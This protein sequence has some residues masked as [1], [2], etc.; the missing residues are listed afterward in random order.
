MN[1]VDNCFFLTDYTKKKL[2]FGN[3]NVFSSIGSS[4]KV[5]REQV[6]RHGLD[7]CLQAAVGVH[8]P[9]PF[10][11]GG[12]VT[13]TAGGPFSPAVLQ[14]LEL[15][16]GGA[17]G[18]LLQPVMMII[19]RDAKLSVMSKHS[20][21]YKNQMFFH[22]V[23]GKGIKEKKKD[24]YSQWALGQPGFSCSSWATIWCMKRGKI[25][26]P[27]FRT[28]FLTTGSKSSWTSW[29]RTSL[30]L[31]QPQSP[32]GR[33]KPPTTAWRGCCMRAMRGWSC[34]RPPP[35]YIPGLGV[36]QQP[37]RIVLT[38]ICQIGK[39]CVVFSPGT[40]VMMPRTLRS[41]SVCGKCSK[42]FCL[43]VL[44]TV[45]ACFEILLLAPYHQLWVK[46]IR[47]IRFD[48]QETND[49]PKTEQ[50]KK[51]IF[52][53]ARLERVILWEAKISEMK[54]NLRKHYEVL[55]DRTYTEHSVV[56]SQMSGH[57]GRRGEDLT[58]SV[59][60]Y[61]IPLPK[62]EQ[63]LR[64]NVPELN[65]QFPLSLSLVLRCMLLVAKADDKEDANA[66]VLIHVS[67]DLTQLNK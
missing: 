35:R 43:R 37:L 7:G 26:T 32:L 6:K 48:E 10:H 11:C 9:Q 57:A 51:S 64:S 19:T 22:K 24:K 39:V 12:G 1:S 55:L 2:I 17:A 65:D 66:K 46:R 8:R 62:T 15:C 59:F 5:V 25:Q 27:E 20:S 16:S 45:P 50:R 14:T 63:L 58:G 21:K 38:K 67:E 34:M 28:L 40:I 41:T 23:T 60:F 53:R 52:Q 47:Y 29:T 44:I 54:K 30:Q 31:S 61:N 4:P 13:V 42:C 3:C 33:P 49:I 18:T 36:R 56:D